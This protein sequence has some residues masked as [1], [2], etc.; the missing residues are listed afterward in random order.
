MLKPE[1]SRSRQMKGGQGKTVKGK[2][3]SFDPTFDYLLSMYVNQKTISKNQSSKGI[4]APSLKQYRSR[5]YR[6]G[7]TSIVI[8]IRSMDVIIYDQV[9]QKTLD[10]E[11]SNKSSTSKHVQPK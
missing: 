1:E 5:S 2:K 11:I 6:S 4:A 3:E 7:Q 9:N 8:K 10:H